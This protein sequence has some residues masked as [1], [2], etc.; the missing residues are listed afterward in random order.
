MEEELAG[1]V[2]DP[3]HHEFDVDD[4][5]VARQHQAFLGDVADGDGAARGAEQIGAGQG[6]HTDLDAIDV[7]DRRQIDRLDR[8]GPA[9]LQARRQRSVELAEAQ[10]DALLVRVHTDG[11]RVKGDHRDRHEQDQSQKAAADAAAGHGLLQ[12]IL[13][14]L[15]Q[16]FEIRR[17]AAAGR[18]LAPGPAA[19]PAT[20]AAVL[21]TPGHISY[22]LPL[23]ISGT[24]PDRARLT[25]CCDQ[26]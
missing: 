16:L 1:V 9:E 13:T 19:F 21:T 2:D 5:L 6:L 23:P 10:D 4:V 22:P 7:R 11:K 15:Q 20:P 8:I 17:W 3:E 18:T 24:H 14:S 12:A 25:Q 26:Y